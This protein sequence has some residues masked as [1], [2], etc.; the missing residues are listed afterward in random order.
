[1]NTSPQHPTDPRLDRLRGAAAPRR[2]NARTIAA[3]TTNPG[4]AR[5][6]VLD[7]A[8]VDK[9]ALARHVGFP[10]PFGQSQ[11]AITRGNA[12]E[13]Q[14]KADGCAELLQLLRETLGLDLAEAAYTDLEDVG[15]VDTQEVRHRHSVQKL[16][17][18]A[19]DSGTLFDHPL[20]RLPVAGEHV[21]LEPDLVAFAHEGVF[22][23][24]EIKSFAVIDGQADPDKVAAAAIQSAVYVL[25]LRRLL[26]R[27]DV[28]SPDVVLVCPADFSNR[29]VATKVDVR[30]QLIILEHQLRRL[31]RVEA[32]LDLLPPGLTL[33]LEPDERGH[34]TRSTA[35]LTAALG[36]LDARYAPGC[37][38]SCEL[39]FFCRD[40]AGGRTDA[41]GTSVREQLGGV[42]TVAEALAIADG[43]WDV[44]DEQA[45]AAAR[46]RASAPVYADAL[47]G[48]AP[49]PTAVPALSVVPAL[50]PAAPLP[51][52]AP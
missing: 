46:L 32:L 47:T 8:G 17:H 37:L 44:P 5:R 27:D 45:E 24:V 33:D 50:P 14:L 6:A 51:V 15:G 30:K 19:D 28:V 49:A 34:P 10:A 41:L 22:H 7:T 36:T 40:E 42:E 20:L 39:G 2:H 23:V 12:F 31:T 48:R 11:F 4:C 38:S 13:A 1:M 18:A 25:A 52:V 3:L 43:T 26:G 21:Y 29:P 16:T 9:D 35:E